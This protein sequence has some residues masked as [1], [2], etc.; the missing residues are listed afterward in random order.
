M[1]HML[2]GT[3]R[4]NAQGHL[5]IG[6]CDVTRLA[7]EFGTPLYVMDEAL[8]RHNCRAYRAAFES[9]YPRNVICYAGK[10][11][12]TTA[13]CRIIEEEGLNLDVAALGELYTA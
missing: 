6:N 10:A 13:M 7:A 5:E 4:I 1:A 9:R 12:L 3:Q 2:L 11:F 8:I